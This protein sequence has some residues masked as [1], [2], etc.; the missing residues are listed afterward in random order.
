MFAEEC[1]DNCCCCTF[2]LKCVNYAHK[3][4]T[5]DFCTVFCSSVNE[6]DSYDA[7]SGFDEQEVGANVIRFVTRFV[8]KVCTESGVTPEH[9]KQLHTMVPGVVAMHIETLENVF[10]EAKRLPPIQKVRVYYQL[11][12]LFVQIHISLR[13]YKRYMMVTMLLVWGKW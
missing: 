1:L 9:I 11:I 8:D 12:L 13:F 6:S 4:F 7:E 3:G 5:C 10:R 2:T